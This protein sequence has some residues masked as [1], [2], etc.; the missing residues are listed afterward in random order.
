MCLQVEATRLRNQN[1]LES[2]VATKRK[3][4]PRSESPDD[5]LNDAEL[6]DMTNP[7]TSRTSSPE[8]PNDSDASPREQRNSQNSDYYSSKRV[9]TIQ[10][11]ESCIIRTTVY[12]KLLDEKNRLLASN[13]RLLR[14]LEAVGCETSEGPEASDGDLKTE[15]ERLKAELGKLALE[16]YRIKYDNKPIANTDT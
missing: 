6:L 5:S 13:K 11:P 10:I 15:N 4:S 14:D 12:R 2:I 16:L 1:F 3:R 9:T 7:V 8:E